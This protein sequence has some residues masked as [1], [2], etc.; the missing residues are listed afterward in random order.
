MREFHA[1]ISEK[2]QS[3]QRHQHGFCQRS[4]ESFQIFPSVGPLA[5]FGESS[6]RGARLA[7]VASIVN[8][9]N[10]KPII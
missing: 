2:S 8:K 6:H 4:V 5:A 7:S 10:S 1:L 9:M 3:A